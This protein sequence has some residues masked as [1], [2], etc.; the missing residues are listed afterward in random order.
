MADSPIFFCGL[1]I[2]SVAMATEKTRG[3]RM[4]SCCHGDGQVLSAVAM[5]G[6]FRFR[7]SYYSFQG[8]RALWCKSRGEKEDKDWIFV[9][10]HQLTEVCA[11]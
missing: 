2:G 7:L 9:F 8:R 4:C 6:C 5:W 11:V 3:S 10:S 1:F